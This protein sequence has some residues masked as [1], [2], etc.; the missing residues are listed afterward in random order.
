[1]LTTKDRASDGIKMNDWLT[2]KSAA[3]IIG[4][5]PSTVRLWSDKGILPSQRTIGG[6]RRYRRANVELWA[7]HARRGNLEPEAVLES[8]VRNVRVQ[9]A[10]GRLEAQG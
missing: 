6:H 10:E 2:L 5:H 9:I 3:A 1:M 7:E 4:V 8:A